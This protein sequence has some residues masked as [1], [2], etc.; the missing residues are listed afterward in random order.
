MF[1]TRRRCKG[2]KS[3]KAMWKENLL[4]MESGI[5]EVALL[6]KIMRAI[7]FMEVNSFT[8]KCLRMLNP[9]CDLIFSQ[10][11]VLSYAMICHI[12]QGRKVTAS[13]TRGFAP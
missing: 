4:S 13:V 9:C 6:I 7:V 3:S 8:H 10:R 2:P 1:H 5:L 12:L 11:L